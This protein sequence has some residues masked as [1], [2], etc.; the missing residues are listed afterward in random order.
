MNL[1][2]DLI[3]RLPEESESLRLLYLHLV[4]RMGSAISR[5][6]VMSIWVSEGEISTGL[7]ADR[8]KL[9]EHFGVLLALAERHGFVCRN[10]TWEERKA[11]SL[12]HR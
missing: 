5:E 12:I 3:R 4:F 11:I 2:E 6:D 1:P 10:P 7:M 9:E 8:A